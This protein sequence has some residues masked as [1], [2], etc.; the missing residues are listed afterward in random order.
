MRSSDT[1]ILYILSSGPIKHGEKAVEALCIRDQLHSLLSCD[2]TFSQ[3]LEYGNIRR[4]RSDHIYECAELR[5]KF[6]ITYGT[7]IDEGSSDGIIR[8]IGDVLH[9][10]LTT[11]NQVIRIV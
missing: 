11:R 4:I 9:G 1:K 5:G 10:R 6:F 8:H 3:C 7:H 2:L